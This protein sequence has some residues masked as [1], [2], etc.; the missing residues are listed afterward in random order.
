MQEQMRGVVPSR[1]GGKESESRGVALPQP[2]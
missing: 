2:Y 1:A